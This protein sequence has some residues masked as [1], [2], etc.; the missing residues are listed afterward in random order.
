MHQPGA[1]KYLPPQW[2]GQ[3]PHHYN[4]PY[5]EY[6]QYSNSEG[7]DFESEEEESDYGEGEGEESG[8]TSELSAY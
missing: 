3:Q 8:T 6:Q 5:Q 2:E 4:A 1:Y 7:E